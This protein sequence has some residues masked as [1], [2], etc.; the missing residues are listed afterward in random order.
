MRKTGRL[1]GV[2]KLKNLRKAKGRAGHLNATHEDLGHLGDA[3]RVQ[4]YLDSH[5]K[6]SPIPTSLTLEYD[7]EVVS[8]GT[9]NGTY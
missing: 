9:V 1:D 6:E 4:L 3:C 7:E 2:F 5:C 8:N